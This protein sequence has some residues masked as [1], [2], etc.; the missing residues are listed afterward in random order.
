MRLPHIGLVIPDWK[1]LSRR[2]P[3]EHYNHTL[4]EVYTNLGLCTPLHA[5]QPQLI[6]D[7]GFSEMFALSNCKTRRR[8]ETDGEMQK[9]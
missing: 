6:V 9:E 3:E 1:L 2:L 5:R 7:F 4:Q 8:G